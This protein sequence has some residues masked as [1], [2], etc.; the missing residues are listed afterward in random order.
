MQLELSKKEFR[1]LLDLVYIGNWILNSTR[2]DDRIA[3]YDQVESKLFAL[4]R[5]NGMTIVLITHH[6]DECVGADRLIVM[7]NGHIVADGTPKDVF[8]DV[9]LMDREGLSVPATVR[10]M[11]ELRDAGWA[12]PEDELDVEDCADELADF[13]KRKENG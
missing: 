2:G 7:S 10:L 5:E 4:C 6:M 8:A 13:I 11:H 9:A 3:D 1:R 12:L